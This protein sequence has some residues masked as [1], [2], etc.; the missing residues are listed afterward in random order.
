MLTFTELHGPHPQGVPGK[1]ILGAGFM[2]MLRCLLFGGKPGLG[3]QQNDEQEK[4]RSADPLAGYIS[5]AL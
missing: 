5:D 3:G 1:S 2:V 4:R